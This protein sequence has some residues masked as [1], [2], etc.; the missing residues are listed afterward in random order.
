MM[1]RNN[2]FCELCGRPIDSKK[3]YRTVIESVVMTVCE[4]CYNRLLKT[5]H[6]QTSLSTNV[7]R[8]VKSKPQVISVPPKVKT[9]KS[10]TKSNIEYDI[11]ADFHIKIKEARER[12]GWSI[13]VLAQKVKERESVIRR[14]EQGKLKPTLDLARRLERVLKIRL[15]EAVGTQEYTTKNSVSKMK[16]VTLGDVVVIRKHQ[17]E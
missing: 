7:Q 9:T 14:I 6:H 15:I 1:V 3:A 11:V 8:V 4:L 16:D 17:G 10:T 13:Q 12:L 2:T 5:T